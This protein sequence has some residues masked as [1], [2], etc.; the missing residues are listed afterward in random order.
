MNKTNQ[1]Y[2]SYSHKDERFVDKLVRDLTIQNFNPIYDRWILEAGNS[3]LDKIAENIS[4]TPYFIIVVSHNSINS[5][6][7]KRELSIALTIEINT[8]KIKV[9]PIKIDNCTLPMILSNKLYV[10]FSYW[11]YE[12]FQKLLVSIKPNFKNW[13]DKYNQASK[14]QLDKLK[15]LKI[16]IDKYNEKEFIKL[17]E[18]NELFLLTFLEYYRISSM[19]SDVVKFDAYKDN[20]LLSFNFTAINY[21]SLGYEVTLIKFINLDIRK[22]TIIELQ[23][24]IS[25]AEDTRIFYMKNQKELVKH[26]GYQSTALDFFYEHHSIFINIKIVFGKRSD[27]TKEYSN[28]REDVFYDSNKIIEIIS[29]DRVLEQIESFID[30]FEDNSIESTKKRSLRQFIDIIKSLSENFK[31]KYFPLPKV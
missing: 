12:S 13:K 5:N 16:S 1:V 7:V 19:A 21:S 9:I 30:Y 14:N 24:T 6:W 2:I 18:D 23:K 31:S 10:D 26:I 20:N 11:Y 8:E 25:L 17:I 27:Y 4:S 29:Y 22:M 3:I 28:F 15:S